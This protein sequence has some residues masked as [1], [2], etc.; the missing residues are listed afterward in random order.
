MGNIDPYTR[1]I[2][3]YLKSPYGGKSS[4]EIASQL[5]IHPRQIN[6]TYSRAIKRGFDPNQRPFTIKPEH[7]EDAPSVWPSF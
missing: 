4:A 6:D 7:V 5:D 2:I 3:V 1:A